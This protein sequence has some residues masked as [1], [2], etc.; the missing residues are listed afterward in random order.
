MK[1]ILSDKNK[2]LA[3]GLLVALSTLVSCKK[4]I[5]IP[6]NPPTQITREQVFADSATT[7]SAVA[8]VFSYT[9]GGHG[10]PYS[11]GLFTAA[12]SLSGH[13]VFYT[14][15]NGDNGQ[16]YNYR[17]TPI[18]EELE[19]LWAMPYAEIYHVNDVLAG[20]TDNSNLSAS[21]VKQITGEMKVVRAFC[22]FNMVNLFGGV[23]LITTT[24]YSVNAQMPRASVDAIYQQILTDLDDAVKKLPE[25]YPSSGH[26]RPNLYTAIALQAKVNLYQERW[27][28]AYNEA[29]SVIKSGLYDITTTPLSDVFL[30]GSAEG[31]WQVPIQNQYAG[32]G[33]ANQFY[34]YS[35]DATPNYIVTDSLLTQFEAGDQRFSNWVGVNVVNGDNVYFPAKYKDLQPTSP[36]TYFMLLRLGEMYLIR[37]EAAAQ[38]GHLEQALAD[39]NI[40]R[41]RAGLG[42]STANLASQTAVLAAVRKERRTELCFEFGN[43]WFDVNRTS[44][45]NKY[46]L[47]GQAAV[48]LANWK[49]D[50][51]LYPLPQ[52]QLQLNTHLSQ[53]PGYN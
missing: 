32:S 8:G 20:I 44:T 15:S 48:V 49:P 29:D 53:N 40:L 7:I 36:A 3:S 14:N 45:D 46:P 13:E 47:N 52:S 26:V 30:E 43:R 42:N 4:L 6:A 12:T 51:G 27:Q 21:F 25:A 37:A 50:F 9:P 2:I 19:Q 35:S 38:L 16:F 5:E 31:I 1:K 23:P 10:I 39:V 18:N 41:N 22:Y 33:D 34:P 11:D 28:A 24:D 17:I